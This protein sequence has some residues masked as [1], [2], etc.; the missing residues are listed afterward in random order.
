MI[1]VKATPDMVH[2]AARFISANDR[3]EFHKMREGRDLLQVLLKGLDETSH[4]IIHNGNVLC[5]G[6][7]NNCLWF[8]TT[9]WVDQLIPRE[10]LQLLGLLKEHLKE[11]ST[12][13]PKEL[14]TN[15]VWEGN[16]QH[17]KLLNHL[18][19]EWGFYQEYSPAG[20]PFRQFWL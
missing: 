20:H 12:R 18:G 13:L 3:A 6:G 1:L 7:S 4:A 14:R 10:R 15:F 5:L 11:V 8:I 19:A 9:T 2:E 17:I 16:E